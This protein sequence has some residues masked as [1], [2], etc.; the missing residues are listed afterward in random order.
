MIPEKIRNYIKNNFKEGRVACLTGAGIS[1]ESGIPTFR[2]KGGLWERYDPEIYA[3]ASGLISTLRT[4]PQ[5]LANFIVDFY[6]VL[7]K[8]LPNSAH[9]ALAALEKENILSSTITQ[10]I[11]GLHRQAG[12]QNVIE[13]HG[14]AFRIR[15]IQCSNTVIF[16]KDKLREMIE[17]FKI[18]KDSY[19]KILKVLS[20]YFPRCVTCGSRYRIDIVLFGE[21]L[22]ADELSRAWKELNN[23][24]VLLL[25]GSSL[26]VYPAAG[27]PLYAKV[28]GAKIIEINNEPSVLSGVCDYIIT[29]QASQILP[30][31]LGVLGYA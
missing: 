25:I 23:C 12:S 18:N 4:H 14:N 8:A 1:A 9:R 13:L 5:D 22:P 7:L 29:G 17:L 19:I 28:R 24:D 26:L 3:N 16:E 31:I 15:C 6:S 20:R 11:D 27:L 2:G 21:M 10:N 30:E